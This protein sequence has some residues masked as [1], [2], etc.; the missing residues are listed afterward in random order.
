MDV[1]EIGDAE[2]VFSQNENSV[3]WVNTP[4]KR[5]RSWDSDSS[6]DYVVTATKSRKQTELRVAGARLP[7]KTN[8]RQ[9]NIWIDS[10]S[11]I[12]HSR[13]TETN[14]MHLYGC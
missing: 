8:A 7:I 12:Y 5:Q 2:D 9:T 14:I 3:G 11:P 13:R 1:S 10:G 4:E 6:G